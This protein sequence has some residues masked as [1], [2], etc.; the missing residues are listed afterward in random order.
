VFDLLVGDM[1]FGSIR[2]RGFYERALWERIVALARSGRT[3]VDVG[4]D[5]GYFTLLWCAA[6]PR[7]T[8]FAFQA[9]PRNLEALWRYVAGNALAFVSTTQLPSDAV[10]AAWAR[11]DAFHREAGEKE[12]RALREQ[13]PELAGS[14]LGSTSDPP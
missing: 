2:V 1:A 11:L 9:A 10:F 6:H 8:A 13:Y 7:A 12:M 14:V 3:L 5:M 4:A